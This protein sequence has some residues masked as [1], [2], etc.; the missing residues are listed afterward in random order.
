MFGLKAL[1]I[2]GCFLYQTIGELIGYE[3]A[4]RIVEILLYMVYY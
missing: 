1:K 3:S 2:F 4:S